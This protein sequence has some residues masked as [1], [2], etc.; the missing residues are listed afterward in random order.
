[1][2]SFIG[3][4]LNISTR[5]SLRR[6]IGYLEPPADKKSKYFYVE[7]LL[8]NKIDSDKAADAV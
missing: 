2:V 7:S 1:M 5:A 4:A 8:P 6:S 3:L